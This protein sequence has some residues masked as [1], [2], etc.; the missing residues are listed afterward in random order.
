MHFLRGAY[1]LA[2]ITLHAVPM[3]KEGIL[4]LLPFGSD[5]MPWVKL[6]VLLAAVY[7]NVYVRVY[8]RNRL[9]RIECPG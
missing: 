2:I 5:R 7:V 3:A 8:G 4:N 1:R 6:S 9:A